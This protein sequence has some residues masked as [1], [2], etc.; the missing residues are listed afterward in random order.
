MHLD[1]ARDLVL[2]LCRGPEPE[3]VALDAALGRVLA[4]PVCAEG[5]VPGEA[6]SRFDGY[7]VRSGD[8]VD[9]GRGTGTF[10]RVLPGLLP[11][12]YSGWR[13]LGSG[14][15]V[16][17]LTGAPLPEGA[18]AVVP[19]EAVVPGLDGV[20]V[21]RPCAVGDGVITP[22]SDARDGE[23]V[24]EPG[25][26]MT[27]TRMA[28]AAALGRDQVVV[29]RSPSVAILS[30]GDE[31]RELG[32]RLGRALT[33]CNTR[34]LLAWSVRE[35][36]G[37]PIH[38]GTVQDD[39]RALADRLATVDADVVLSTGGMGRGD[40]DFV[41][42]AW[43]RLGIRCLFHG[44]NLSPGKRSALGIMAGRLYWGLPGNPWGAQVVFSELIAPSLWAM[45][46]LRTPGPFSI[47]ALLDAPVK[48]TTAGFKALGG[49][50][51]LRDGRIV[52]VPSCGGRDS[53]F[54]GLRHETA[55]ALLDAGRLDWGAGESVRVR[56]HD[57][58]LL[59]S[60]LFSVV[61]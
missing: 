56:F 28:L 26:V 59:A 58:P 41:L 15:C 9:A 33:H 48:N 51:E 11:A 53:R 42:E 60:S 25:T 27:P 38:L 14:E 10:L 57:F 4:E 35:Q 6:R 3:V 36:G 18:D 43:E 30:T 45:Q 21:N 52:F 46:G 5:D 12:G 44:L 16:R 31:V 23:T 22:G 32:G 50:V 40:R 55:Y 34:Y 2:N 54:I 47:L 49:S 29:A 39:P 19:Q 20:Q 8:L 7:A 17:I 37:R 24:L 61:I 1:E 13:G